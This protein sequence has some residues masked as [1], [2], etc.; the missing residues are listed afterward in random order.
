M[1]KAIVVVVAV[2]TTVYSV[3]SEHS[4]VLGTRALVNISHVIMYT[5]H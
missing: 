5:I 4:T 3:H 2:F 1:F